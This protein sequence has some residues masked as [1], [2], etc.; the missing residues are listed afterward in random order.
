MS[1][2]KTTNRAISLLVREL[3]LK[4]NFDHDEAMEFLVGNTEKKKNTDKKDKEATK[5]PSTG[6]ARRI[7]LPWT[8]AIEQENCWALSYNLGLFT[9]CENKA[10][11]GNKYC[12]SCIKKNEEHHGFPYGTVD[13]RIRDNFTG[14]GGK[15][16]V[17]YGNIIDKKNIE[18]NAVLAYAKERNIEIPDEMFEV[19]KRPRGRPKKKES[20]VVNDTSSEDDKPKKRGRPAGKKAVVVDNRDGTLLGNIINGS[21]PKVK[22]ENS[23]KPLAKSPVLSKRVDDPI[24]LSREKDSDD[25]SD[26]DDS[27]E[28]DGIDAVEFIHDGVKYWKTDDNELYDPETQ[29]H[30]LNWDPENQRT[31][32]I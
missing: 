23:P 6:R 3:S 2:V 12:A 17:H 16:L 9:Q 28:D 5:K 31:L 4:Y 29:N 7:P 14:A 10:E 13:D 27:D 19:I 22:K 18:K 32:V 8:G 20:I 25:D 24:L 15:P 11:N 1:V 26:D 21:T 30:V